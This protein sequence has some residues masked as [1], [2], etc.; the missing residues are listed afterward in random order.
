M[1]FFVYLLYTILHDR[2]YVGQ[3]NDVDSRVAL[4]NSGKVRSTKY[5]RPWVLVYQEKYQT[6]AEAMAREKWLKSRLGRVFVAKVLADWK[7]NGLS[8]LADWKA[9][10][11]SVSSR[12]SAGRTGSRP[13]EVRTD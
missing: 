13:N 2:T 3:T 1:N 10:G 12:P 8:V 6:R 4:H 9:N 7:A 5:Y 11:L